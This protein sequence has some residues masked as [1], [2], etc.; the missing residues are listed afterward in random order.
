LARPSSMTSC[1][2]LQHV[3][4]A[5]S[6]RCGVALHRCRQPSRCHAAWLTAPRER[7]V[8]TPALLPLSPSSW[9]SA[10]SMH[11][12]VRCVLAVLVLPA[13]AAERATSCKSVA[14]RRRRRVCRRVDA[15][16]WRC[17][18]PV[19]HPLLGCLV[20]AALRVCGSAACVCGVAAPAAADGGCDAA[21][22]RRRSCRGADSASRA[23]AQGAVTKCVPLASA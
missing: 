13:A 5:V 18:A 14:C 1:C 3:R 21:T 6:H 19:L 11:C 20:S 7:C 22:C 9:H 16:P 12:R 15:A 2:R 4:V 10:L 8:S 23:L 17:V